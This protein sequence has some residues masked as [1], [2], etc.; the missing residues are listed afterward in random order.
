VANPFAGGAEAPVEIYVAVDGDDPELAART[1]DPIRRLGTV[2]EDDVALQSYADT[3]ASVRAVLRIL[4]EVR[5]SEWSPFIVVR[6]VG[7][8]ASRVP[9]DATA[10]A[11]RRA[12]LMVVTTAAGTE[13]AVQA[14]RPRL[15]GIWRRLAP[16]VNG[17]YANFLASAAE[18]DVAAIYPMETYTRLAAVKRQFDPG[19]LFAHNHNIRPR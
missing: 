16:Y 4:A 2:T 5:A 14:A 12:E 18:A 19:N 6:S 9:H 3:L 10:F 11:F 17:A 15:D 8:A 7:G 1:I 13:P